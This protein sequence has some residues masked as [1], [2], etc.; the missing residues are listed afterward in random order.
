M[1]QKI[2]QFYVCSQFC[3]VETTKADG[4]DVTRERLCTADGATCR[5]EVSF[6]KE[7]GRGGTVSGYVCSKY[8]SKVSEII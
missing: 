1:S 4:T 7:G 2:T 6:S 5:D 8:E 3:K